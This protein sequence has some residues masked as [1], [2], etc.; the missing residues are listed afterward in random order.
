[1]I[2]PYYDRGGITIY[3]G[4]CAEVMNQLGEFDLLLTD[5]PYGIGEDGGLRERYRRGDGRV[6]GC[7]K[8]KKL[9]WD[10]SRPSIDIFN[11]MTSLSKTWMIFGGNYFADML[12]A[13]SG[14]MY[15]DKKMGG[16]FSDGE[17]IYSNRNVGLR[18]ITMHPFIGLRGGKDRV[19]PTQKPLGVIRWCLSQCP[20]VST[21]LDPFMGS[22]TT[23]LACKLDGIS[24]V[25]IERE[26]A[27]CEAAVKRL[28]QEVL[29]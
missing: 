2:E 19:H 20:D 9:T 10:E 15:W 7:I 17:L 12:P 23:L 29:F 22:G 24:C 5:P 3:H 25:G 4:D 26:E 21:V 1:M 11:Q 18:S 16:D 28:A 14:W 27:Y 8:H 6:R 13:S